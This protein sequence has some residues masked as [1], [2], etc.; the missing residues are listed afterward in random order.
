MK[1]LRKWFLIALA[2][3]LCGWDIYY[4]DELIWH[5]PAGIVADFLREYRENIKGD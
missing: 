3:F 5:S 2:V 1:K 4:K